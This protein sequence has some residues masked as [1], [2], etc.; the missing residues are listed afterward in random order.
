MP[1]ASEAA[2]SEVVRNVRI[3]IHPVDTI[4]SFTTLAAAPFAVR[5]AAT[6]TIATAT[7]VTAAFADVTVAAVAAAVAT[8][9]ATAAPTAVAAVAAVLGQFSVFILKT[10]TA[11]VI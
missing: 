6:A 8:A 5:R 11:T 9:A 10:A 4:A 2:V 1:T 7:A 3:P